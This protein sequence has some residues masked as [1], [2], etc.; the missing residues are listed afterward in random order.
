[1]D[2]GTVDTKMLRAGWGSWGQPVSTATTSFEMLTQ[3]GIEYH[4]VLK[5]VFVNPS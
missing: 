3:D 2:P 4:K 1:M 5:T